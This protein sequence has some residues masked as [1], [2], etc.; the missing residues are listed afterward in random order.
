MTLPKN[1]LVPTLNGYKVRY[2]NPEGHH[3]YLCHGTF[4]CDQ[5]DNAIVFGSKMIAGM[6]A[7]F[8]DHRRQKAHEA[9][10]K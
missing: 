1:E 10:H 6:V 4:W 8:W 7:I 2:T 9:L 3:S 5:D